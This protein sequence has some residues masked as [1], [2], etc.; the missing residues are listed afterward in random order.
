M[1]TRRSAPY[2]FYAFQNRSSVC[3]K[4]QLVH[5][6]AS[7]RALKEPLVFIAGE[8][9]VRRVGENVQLPT[10]LNCTLDKLVRTFQICPLLIVVLEMW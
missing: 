1:I 5:Y 7:F 4:F 9:V 8:G 6:M 3:L 2:F 10:K